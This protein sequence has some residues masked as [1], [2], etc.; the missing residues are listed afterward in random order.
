MTLFFFFFSLSACLLAS[1]TGHVSLLGLW[2]R[3][4]REVNMCPLIGLL[5][6]KWLRRMVYS[7]CYLIFIFIFIFVLFFY[8]MLE[9]GESYL[10]LYQHTIDYTTSFGSK[11]IFT[12]LYVGSTVMYTNPKKLPITPQGGRRDLTWLVKWIGIMTVWHIYDST[13]PRIWIATLKN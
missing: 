9:R 11:N 2:I 5:E 13:R 3:R 8:S 7:S 4:S 12:Q 6:V 10:Y 1:D